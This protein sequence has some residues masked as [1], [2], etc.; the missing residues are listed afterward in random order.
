MH[1]S[2]RSGRAANS[3]GSQC[4]SSD[5]L[6]NSIEGASFSKHDNS[7]LL[8]IVLQVQIQGH[9][10]AYDARSECA[11]PINRWGTYRPRRSSKESENENDSLEN[12]YR[13]YLS[14]NVQFLCLQ[15]L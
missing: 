12:C 15:S 5:K 2:S 4:V 10:L 14:S 13:R 1:L 9:P 6:P 8:E 7:I 11:V 3:K